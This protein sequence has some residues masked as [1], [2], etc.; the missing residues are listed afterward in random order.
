MGDPSIL[1]PGSSVR[2]IHALDRAW[3]V[4]PAPPLHAGEIGVIGSTKPM[5]VYLVSFPSGYQY[6]IADDEMESLD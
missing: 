1:T 4:M 6:W 5:I 2:V 3:Q